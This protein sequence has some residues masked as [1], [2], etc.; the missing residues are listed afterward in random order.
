MVEAV[1]PADPEKLLLDINEGKTLSAGELSTIAA[2]LVDQSKK[3]LTRDFSVDDVYSYLLV[4]GRAKCFEYGHVLESFL[5]VEDPLTVAL[6]LEILC[7]DWGKSEEYLERVI[8]FAL[9]A[10]WDEDEDVRQTAL[11]IL[12]EYLYEKLPKQQKGDVPTVIRQVLELLY[13]TF[14]DEDAEQW[15][16]KSAYTALCRARKKK[17]EQ[18]PAECSLLSFEPQSPDIDWE[19]IRQIEDFLSEKD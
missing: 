12:G 9:G 1:K 13:S 10:S 16:R 5:D 19:V 8:N 18:L 6:V 11:K 4:L 3:I 2:V 14:C 7:L 15:S 17:P